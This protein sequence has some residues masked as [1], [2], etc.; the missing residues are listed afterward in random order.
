MADVGNYSHPLQ[1]PMD[2]YVPGVKSGPWY[3]GSDDPGIETAI[4]EVVAALESAAPDIR[5]EYLSG[6]LYKVIHS[7]AHTADHLAS[8]LPSAEGLAHA[9]HNLPPGALRADPTAFDFHSVASSRAAGV[10]PHAR[11]RAMG[12]CTRLRR[13]ACRPC[14][15]QRAP[16]VFSR[17]PCSVPARKGAGPARKAAGGSSADQNGVLS[18]GSRGSYT[19]PLGTIKHK[20]KDASRGGGAARWVQRDHCRAR[21]AC[22]GR[23]QSTGP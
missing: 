9:C 22:L 4:A 3:T 11:G 21:G 15:A 8:L 13:I 2:S 16:G 5:A 12:L 18:S 1:L 6:D 20:A 17:N 19:A 7:L 23:G 14:R 10:S